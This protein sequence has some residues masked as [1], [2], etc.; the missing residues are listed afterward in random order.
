VFELVSQQQE[1][2]PLQ[3]PLQSWS[4]E[5]P[6]V[7]VP[8]LPLLPDASSPTDAS[9]PVFEEPEWLPD[10]EY[11]PVFDVDPPQAAM[12]ARAPT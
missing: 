7:C 4:D 2:A 12:S 1:L 3:P 11:V 10:D 5:Q 8:S 9:S 6:L